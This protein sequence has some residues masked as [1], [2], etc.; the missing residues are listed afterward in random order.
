[1]ANGTV[2]P[3]KLSQPS[4][5][6]GYWLIKLLTNSGKPMSPEQVATALLR[7]VRRGRY[8]IVPDFLMKVGYYLRGFIIP[9]VNWAHDQFV[10]LA[11]KQRGAQ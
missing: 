11:R 5:F 9:L 8:L 2:K 4:E 1:M 3:E 6:L 7:D 10:P